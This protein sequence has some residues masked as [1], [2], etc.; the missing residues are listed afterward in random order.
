M[1]VYT[2]IL[3]GLMGVATA[4]SMWGAAHGYG[5]S[6]PVKETLSVREGSG[7]TGGNG[8]VRGR[9]YIYGGGIHRGK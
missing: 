9:R 8:K 2:I 3:A 4:G 5:L 1:N 6:E 7:R